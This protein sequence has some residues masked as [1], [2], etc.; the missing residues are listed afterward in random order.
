[1]TLHSYTVQSSCQFDNRTAKYVRIRSVEIHSIFILNL[2]ARTRVGTHNLH[3][4][5]VQ[6]W[7]CLLFVLAVCNLLSM[8]MFLCYGTIDDSSLDMI[9]SFARNFSLPYVTS[10]V[11]TDNPYNPSDYLLYI[12]PSYTQA[13][14]DVIRHAKWD[15]VFYIYD[16]NE[17]RFWRFLQAWPLYD[18]LRRCRSKLTNVRQVVIISDQ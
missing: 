4:M 10:S 7:Y 12:R 1:M 6:L 17:G 11:P 18:M 8:G 13:L 2:L 14:I 5:T 9:S 15:H 16:N 3:F